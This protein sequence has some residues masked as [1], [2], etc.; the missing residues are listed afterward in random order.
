MS[1]KQALSE[2][3]EG[4]ETPPK[5]EGTPHDRVPPNRSRLRRWLLRL[6]AVALAGAVSLLLAELLCRLVM[7]SW[8]PARGERAIFW[9]YDPHLGWSHRPNQHGRFAGPHWNVTVRHNA[10][11]LRDVEHDYAN[12]TGTPRLLILGD[13]YGWGFA[14]EQ[15]EIISA[16][17]AEELQNW[18]VINGSV[19][20]YSTDQ[21]WLWYRRDGHRYGPDWVLL[22]I[23][24]NDIA[25]NAKGYY[26]DHNKPRFFLEDG[27][28]E[29][30]R[31]PVP[32]ST[33]YERVRN[34]LVGRT[35]LG[36]GIRRVEWQLRTG[37]LCPSAEELLKTDA[38]RFEITRSIL[39]AFAREL[40]S[41]YVAF[42]LVLIP[43][44]ETRAAWIR[45]VAQQNEIPILDL[46]PRFRQAEARGAVLTF[47]R[48]PHWNAA[49]HQLAASIIANWLTDE[50][51]HAPPVARAPKVRK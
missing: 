46:G 49:G 21:Q 2:R 39:A 45:D 15:D 51:L 33:L 9:R 23:C 47:E 26:H 36:N 32:R 37:G 43:M 24:R 42:G 40:R 35:Y 34:W 30:A 3:N 18:E 38:E 48:D 11:G 28:L 8:Q 27:K 20:G 19:S 41:Q 22:L 12:P 25:G 13:S 50:V 29:L 16:R 14:V 31:V 4:A 1:A 6:A 7:P 5:S 17:L 10:H 44:D